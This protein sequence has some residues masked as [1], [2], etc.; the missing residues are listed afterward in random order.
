MRVFPGMYTLG[1]KQHVGFLREHLQDA[2]LWRR[3]ETGLDGG[4]S[5]ADS[6]PSKTSADPM[7]N[8]EVGVASELSPAEARAWPVYLSPLIRRWIWAAP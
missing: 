8:T 4:R 5:W 1:W 6:T 7:G 2:H 3:K